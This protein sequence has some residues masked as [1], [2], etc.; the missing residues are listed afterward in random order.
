[1]NK[2]DIEKYARDHLGINVGRYTNKEA[3]LKEIAQSK[4]YEEYIASLEFRT[5]WRKL[6]TEISII[7]IQYKKWIKGYFVVV[8]LAL[9]WSLLFGFF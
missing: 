4:H 7:V 6:M 2:V 5:A 3:L 8:G 9:L 1:M